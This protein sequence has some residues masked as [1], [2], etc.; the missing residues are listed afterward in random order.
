VVRPSA[1]PTE[2]PVAE[3]T[4]T[5]PPVEAPPPTPEP[6]P[7]EVPVEAAPPT[8]TPVVQ[9][10]RIGGPVI[11]PNNHPGPRWVTLQ[12]G[13]W[14]AESL[15]DELEH[16]G[17]RTGTAAGGV[18]EWE[19]NIAVCKLA[20]Q[21]LFERGYSVDILDATVP[22]SYTTDLFVAV[23]A[24]G[25]ESPRWRGFKA[26]A[27]WVSVPASDKFVEIFYEEYGKATGLPTDVVTSVAM[28]DYYA[29]NQHT[30]RHAIDARRVPAAI[31]EMGFVTNPLDRQVLVEQQDR[32]AWGIANAVDRFFRSGAVGNTPTPY[33][34]FT[35]SSTPT[36]IPTSTATVTPTPTTTATE[37]PTPMPN[38][39][40]P[41]ATETALAASPTP[42]TTTAPSTATPT[43]TPSPSATPLLPVVTDDGRWLPPLAMNGRVYPAPGS[44]AAPVFLNEATDDIYFT[45]DGREVQQVWQQYYVPELGRPVWRK[46]PL[47]NV[48]R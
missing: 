13:H 17:N 32:V 26:V 3:A 31:I 38:E 22:M 36:G 5:T 28:A 34:S 29:F 35:P 45:P 20:A 15:P 25:N 47:L 43:A 1:A 8:E 19:I 33:P 27:P 48:R 9:A 18:T 6:P 23:H 24:D 4:A 46:G 42:T 10:D 37:T 14:R 16:L 44:K 40:A 7:A 39:W 41:W 21:Y 12:A 11:E 30:Y 2:E